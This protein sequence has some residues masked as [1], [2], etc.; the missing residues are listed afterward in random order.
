MKNFGDDEQEHD[1]R[2]KKSKRASNR[3][4]EGMRV[5]NM[6]FEDEYDYYLDLDDEVDS[7]DEVTYNK[8]S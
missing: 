6:Q 8:T 4:G 1:V 5:I 2:R 7:D 3:P